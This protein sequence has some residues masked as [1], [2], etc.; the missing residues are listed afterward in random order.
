[1]SALFE[2]FAE[3]IKHY[4]WLIMPFFVLGDDEIGHTRKWKIYR[5]PMKH[6]WNWKC[7]FM[8]EAQKESAALQSSVLSIQS[9]FTNDGR[10][11]SLK[12]G[13]AHRVVDSRK[14]ILG[15]ADSDTVLNDVL[16]GPV[17]KLVPQT[18]MK[19]ILTG[20][21]FLATLLKKA[22]VR[23]KRLGVEV[24]DVW[25]IDCC[26]AATHRILGVSLSGSSSV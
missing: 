3:F 22:K 5:K 9:L 2:K 21:D 11:V 10:E 26:P 14:Y 17:S 24:D 16:C 20:E 8:H 6:G 7:P 18:A 25:L 13:M 15:L 19:E 23:S 12:L 1:M 4:F